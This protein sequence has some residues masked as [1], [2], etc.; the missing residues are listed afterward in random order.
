MVAVALGA[1]VVAYLVAAYRPSPAPGP[2]QVRNTI[3]VAESGTLRFDGTA[4]ARGVEPLSWL[5]PAIGAGRLEVEL[6]ARTDDADQAGPARLL[7]LSTD[8]QHANLTIAQEDD[9]LVVRLRRPGSSELGT[10]ALVADGVFAADRWRAVSLRIADGLAVV[11]VGGAEVATEELGPDP[12]RGWSREVGLALGNEVDAPRGWSGAI[13]R[14][15]VTS[16]DVTVDH[17]DRA[18]YSLPASVRSDVAPEVPAEQY[19][20]VLN[21]VG[22]VPFGALFLLLRPGAHPVPRALLASFVMS[23]AMEAGQLAIASRDP[24]LRDLALN[25]A[26]GTIGGVLV[27]VALS[28]AGARRTSS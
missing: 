20:V 26:G 21:L 7:T 12:L 16:G 5:A 14:A 23:A 1:M 27:V 9:D 4:V 15:T 24:S 11:E 3:E 28:L 2:P 6:E 8:T 10:P 13:R 22:F 25:T 18:S 19:D 17:L